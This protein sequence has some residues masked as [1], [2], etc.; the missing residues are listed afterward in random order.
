MQCGRFGRASPHFKVRIDWDNN[1]FESAGDKTLRIL[2]GSTPLY[3]DCPGLGIWTN[4]GNLMASPDARFDTSDFPGG[5]ALDTYSHAPLPHRPKRVLH[6]SPPLPKSSARSLSCTTNC[7]TTTGGRTLLF[8]NF[9][10]NGNIQRFNMAT[11]TDNCD[12]APLISAVRSDGLPLTDPYPTGHTTITWTATDTCG[13]TATCNQLITVTGPCGSA[14][15]NCDGD[16]GTDSDIE[17]FFACLAGHCPPPPCTSSA[18]FNA[19]GDIGT[20]ADIE[21]FFRVL[22][23][24]NC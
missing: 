11:A 14:D 7:L 4:T 24:G 8:D 1:G 16:I 6:V 18:D 3:N 20:D 17:A 15:F 22:G 19:D 21:A 9:N 12:P 2:W 5:V 10:I 23:G 13:N